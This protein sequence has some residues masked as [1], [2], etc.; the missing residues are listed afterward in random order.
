MRIP[1]NGLV[2][3]LDSSEGGIAFL[4]HAHSDHTSGIRRHKQIISSFETL[5]LAGIDLEPFSCDGVKT[6]DAGHILG[7]KQLVADCDGERVVY[8]GDISLKPN[9][10]GF[11]ADIAQCDHL[12]IEATYGDPKYVFPPAEAVYDMIH[13]WLN[14]NSQNNLLIGCYELGKAQEMIRILNEYGIAPLVTK[15]TEE[16]CSIYEKYGVKL[17]RLVLGSEEAEEVMSRS[18]VSIVPMSRAKRYFAYRLAEAFE[19]PTYCAVATGWALYHRFDTDIAF[20]LSDHADFHDLV[21]YVEQSGAKKVEFF[22]GNGTEVL[23]ARK[24]LILNK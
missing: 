9:I 3:G 16:F 4:S 8:T 12:V 1:C 7:A 14:K 21:Y 5:D 22:C 19:R 15:K 17:D 18:F 2:I 20:P 23:K 10:L 6:I 13:N 11:K 24:S